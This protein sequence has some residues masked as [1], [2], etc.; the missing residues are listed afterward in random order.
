MTKTI[1]EVMTPNPTI[2]A[3]NT[4]IADAARYMRDGDVGDVLVGDASHLTGIVTDRDIV[5]RGWPRTWAPKR[6]GSATSAATSS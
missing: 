5:V 6:R 4:T 1:E 2:C 3:P